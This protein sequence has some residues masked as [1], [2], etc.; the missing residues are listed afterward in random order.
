MEGGK[1]EGIERVKGYS[2]PASGV[3]KG[4]KTINA[5]GTGE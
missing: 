5:A 3:E 4:V 2:G 1:Y